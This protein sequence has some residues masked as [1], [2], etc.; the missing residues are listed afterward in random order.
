MI[1]TL[2][3]NHSGFELAQCVKAQ[4]SLCAIIFISDEKQYI[5]KAFEMKAFQFFKEDIDDNLLEKELKRVMLF[6]KRMYV[7]CVLNTKGGVM[8]FSPQDIIYIETRDHRIRIM[9]TNGAFFGSVGDLIKMKS[10]LMYFHFFQIHQSY[11]VNMEHIISMRRGE[12][13]LTNG[14][15][16]PTSI[17]NRQCVK[18]TIMKFLMFP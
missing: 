15:T 13:T 11:F 14:E 2:V 3:Q 6:Y 16:I 12:I 8:T 5:G 10:E 17:L 4:N 7:K 18:E 9:S 1:G